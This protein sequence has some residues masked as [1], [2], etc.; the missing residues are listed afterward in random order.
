MLGL[1]SAAALPLLCLLLTACGP[2]QATDAP[3]GGTAESAQP[4]TVPP[5][6]LA[7]SASPSSPS[8]T[9]PAPTASPDDDGTTSTLPCRA[10]A[11][12][13]GAALGPSLIVDATV[14]EQEGCTY[15]LRSQGPDA[16]PGL[17]GIVDVSLEE[18]GNTDLSDIRS[19]LSGGE[20]LTGIGDAA[21]WAPDAQVLYAV[22]GGD[23]Y[24]VQL[25]TF[26]VDLDDPKAVTTSIM[27]AL[28]AKI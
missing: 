4:A 24:A 13:I 16:V 27:Q 18:A 9:E 5:P 21:Y 3:P 20:D 15:N 23:T 19:F 22:A 17:G 25:A 11:A 28:F 12:D 2:A 7:T 6:T 8:I 1:R 26:G 10:L 14:L